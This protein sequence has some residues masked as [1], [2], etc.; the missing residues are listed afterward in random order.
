MK[1]IRIK[2][3]IPFTL[4]MMFMVIGVFAQDTDSLDLQKTS[5]AVYPAFGYQPE[6]SFQLGV[7]SVIVFKGGDDSQTEFV[8]RSSV[9]PFI[10]YTFRNQLLSEFELEYYFRNGFNL[11]TETGFYN[12]PD[13]F[14]G[15][16]NDNDPD[17]FERYT[18][19]Y[20]Y[21]NG[22]LFK[23]MNSRVFV[24]ISYDFQYN[25]LKDVEE[26]DRLIA[27]NVNGIR[28]GTL[29]GMGAVIKHDSRDNAIYPTKGSFFT[30]QA[31][32]V[33]LGDYR[34]VDYRMD[35][36]KFLSIVSDKN[37]VGFQLNANLTSGND[38]P[39]YKLPQ[40]GGGSRLRGIA[41]SNLYRDK[42]AL[43]GQVEYRRHLFWR[44]GGVAFAGIGDVAE[45]FGDFEMSELKYVV[46]VGGRFAAI[47]SQRLNFR[48]DMGI[49]RG[50]QLGFYVGMREAF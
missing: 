1:S 3:K 7:V 2:L 40:L 24:G 38:V 48:V 10:L 29:F 42:Q 16:G 30:A 26:T 35:F 33:F 28:G 31:T 27:E 25:E 47:E 23:P 5:V 37:I 22:Q 43:F 45:D 18:N 19:Q 50:G 17:L 41:H 14:Y 46:G 9:T 39:F 4:T 11:N 12:F 21:S 20:F 15:I 36:R 49:A 8:R 32:P 44:F 6:T 13:S 34:Y